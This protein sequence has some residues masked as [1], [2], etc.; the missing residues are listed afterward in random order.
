MDLPGL[1]RLAYSAERAAAYAYQ[2]H[3]ASVRDAAERARIAVIEAEEWQ[4]REHAARMMR[5]LG[6]RPSRYLELK[7]A[8]IGRIIGWS[9][10]VIGYFM[11]MYFAGRL[12]SGN[13]NEYLRLIELV[14]GTALAD[15]YAC[16]LEMAR[17]EKEHEMWFLERV[18]G[19]PWLPRFTGLFGWGEG[20]SF[21]SFSPGERAAG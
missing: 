16:I 17:V 19:H 13:V 11:P 4:H 6:V 1:L 12:E 14:R 15:E 2:G 5:R 8:V 21:N 3:A 20:R 9:C 18:S 7:Y 10:H